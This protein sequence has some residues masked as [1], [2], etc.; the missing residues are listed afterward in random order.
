MN[1]QTNHYSRLLIMIGLHFIAM[2]VLMYSMVNAF[3]NVFNN[4]NQ[5]YMAALMTASM[6]LIELPLMSSMYKSRRLNAFI[7]AVGVAVLIGSFLLIR[8]QSLISDRQFLLSMI[9]HHGGAILMCEKASIQDQKIQE[10]CK[11]I[12][13]GQQAEIDQMKRKLDELAR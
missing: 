10:L 6:I 9:P 5:V 1:M 11:N 8:Q 4:F 3:N 7:I 2:Y 13:S 12:I